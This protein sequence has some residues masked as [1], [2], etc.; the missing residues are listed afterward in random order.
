MNQSG[1]KSSSNNYGREIRRS[2]VKTKQFPPKNI[3][4]GRNSWERC[5]RV[6]D[7][8]YRNKIINWHGKCFGCNSLM[9]Y[10][11]NLSWNPQIT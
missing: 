9:A 3:A 11:G 4:I 10:L 6:K 2:T 7:I 5:N 1:R 8:G